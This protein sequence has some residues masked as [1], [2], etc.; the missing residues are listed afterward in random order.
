[1]DQQSHKNQAS[2]PD[3]SNFGEGNSNEYQK[4]L[5]WLCDFDEHVEQE[6]QQLKFNYTTGSLGKSIRVNNINRNDEKLLLLNHD[7]PGNLHEYD[8]ILIDMTVSSIEQFNSNQSIL[9]NVHE[10]TALAFKTCFPQSI[11]HPQPFASAFLLAK[12]I[13]D[14]SNKKS[15]VVAF[16]GDKFIADYEI[17]KINQYGF[18]ITESL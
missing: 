13:K 2:Q 10:K 17:G 8:I 4:P 12:E 11:F 5:I 9:Q 7:F 18:C 1:M 14:L 6:L 16:I 15:I 3:I